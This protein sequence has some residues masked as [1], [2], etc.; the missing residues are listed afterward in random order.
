MPS[1]I[2]P[3]AIMT[4]PE[5]LIADDWRDYKLLDSGDRGKLEQVGPYRFVRPEPQALW[6]PRLPARE[7]DRADA[8]FAPSGDGD[9][10]AGRWRFHAS[11]PEPWTMRWQDIA[12]RS[13]PTPFRHLAFFPE[14]SVHWRYAREALQARPANAPQA[15]VLNLFGYTGLATLVCAAAGARV[16]H[17]DASKKAIG[18]ARDNQTAAGLETAPVRWIV[19]DASAF[20]KREL[21]RGRRY[22]GI[23]L[24]PPKFGRGPNG[25]TWRLEEQIGDLLA[26]CGA[27]LRRQPHEAG[28]AQGFL[29][30]TIYAVRLS[31]IALAQTA[32][33]ALVAT[34]GA[35]ESG[36][37]CL[38]HAED[39]R[40]LP[41]AI[42]AR[43]RG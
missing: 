26:D 43:W 8:R 22:D 17:V 33:A 11:P 6:R 18:Y 28:S 15:E 4:A 36:E 3:N 29:I 19:D 13:R 31:Y 2:M 40:L 16:T 10:D 9:D 37:M 27:L 5:L 7:W 20:V 38:P 32:R 14:H 12:F 21:R 41:T 24:D 34:H 39:E 42:Y 1:S 23:I 35:W 30:A 25:E